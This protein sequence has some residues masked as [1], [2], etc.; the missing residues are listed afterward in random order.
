[1]GKLGYMVKRITSMDYGAMFKT[2]KEVSKITGKNSFVVLM[3]IIKCG[4]KYMAGYVDYKVFKMYNLNEEQRK[5]ADAQYDGCVS[6][7]SAT[8]FLWH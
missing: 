6:S 8:V 2:A 7:F 3:D 4:S 1:M 5:G